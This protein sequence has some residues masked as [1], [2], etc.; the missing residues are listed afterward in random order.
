[1]PY[2][3]LSITITVP[4]DYTTIQGAVDAANPGDVI[5]VLPGTYSGAFLTKANITITGFGDP[6]LVIISGGTGMAV[7]DVFADHVTVESMTITGGQMTGVFVGGDFAIIE[8]NIIIDNH[9]PYECFRTYGNGI[10]IGD[11]STVSYVEIRNNQILDNIGSCDDGQTGGGIYCKAEYFIIEDNVIIGNMAIGGQ[12]DYGGGIY[13]QGGGIISGNVIAGN[14]T[15]AL[16]S[17]THTV[18]SY[19]GGVY[20]DNNGYA[21]PINFTN[22][23]VVGNKCETSGGIGHD[24]E[25]KGG[26]I[27][28]VPGG[29]ILLDRNIILNNTCIVNPFKEGRYAISD[30]GGIY[31]DGDI[32]S[33][34]ANDVHNNSPNSS[35]GSVVILPADYNFFKDPLLCDPSSGNYGINC[36]SPCAPYNS[37]ISLLIGALNVDCYFCGDLNCDGAINVLDIVYLVNYKFKSGPEPHCDPITACSDVNND[38]QVNVL[39]IIYLVDYKFKGGPAPNCP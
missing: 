23:T 9:V 27:Y 30:G 22:N 35:G 18:E 29:T 39:D 21:S 4:T 14:T 36:P 33:I 5:S 13:C 24:L 20:L 25:A 38:G 37:P 16:W 7:F 8:S 6:S 19:G 17:Y 1:M 15:E 10:S 28:C 11:A 32:A 34:Y 3:V 12:G 26:G 31:S 2:S